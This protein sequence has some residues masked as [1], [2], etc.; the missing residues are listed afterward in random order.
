LHDPLRLQNDKGVAGQN[1]NNSPIFLDSTSFASCPRELTL[2][3]PH[4][5]TAPSIFITMPIHSPITSFPSRP[6]LS[7][8]SEPPTSRF[9]GV[10]ELHPHTPKM[11]A[12]AL[13][14]THVLSSHSP[15]HRGLRFSHSLLSVSPPWRHWSSL[16]VALIGR[17]VA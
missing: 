14:N 8:S 6:H 9:F 5:S 12:T 2:A 10:S 1:P 7:T 15:R 11:L 3:E 13:P 16:R 17:E 4:V